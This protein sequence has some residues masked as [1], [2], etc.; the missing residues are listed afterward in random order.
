MPINPFHYET[1]A[2]RWSFFDRDE[3]LPGLKAFFHERG[4]RLLLVGRRRMGKTSLATNAARE[5]KAVMLFADLSKAANLNEVAKTL[6][7]QIP[8]QEVKGNFE[9]VLDVAGRFS[10]YVSLKGKLF[11]LEIGLVPKNATDDLTALDQ[12]LDF[13]NALS[14]ET[15]SPFTVCLDEFQEIRTL[16]GDRAEWT[17]RGTIQHHR[18]LN[19][20]F[21][22][23]DHRLLGW[24]TEPRAAFYKQLQVLSIGAIPP[25]VIAA[26][27]DKRTG[28]AGVTAAKFG[29]AV[30]AAAGPCTGDVVRLAHETFA[31]AAAGGNVDVADAMRRI[32]LSELGAAFVLLWRALPLTQRAILRAIAADR[33]PQARSTIHDYG[34]GGT[35]GASRAIEGLY[36]RQLLT[37]DEVGGLVFDNPFFRLWVSANKPTEVG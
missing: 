12:V 3:L 11:A 10:K 35:S 37:R 24:M 19:Y 20:V 17:L 28:E 32:A 8:A 30:A 29:A 34:L 1:P 14:E 26:W 13:I 22:G 9:R 7:G 15:D 23:S 4:R 31:Q 25:A 21:L 16:G 5:A 27:I 36:E 18:T 2:D 33:L 6:V